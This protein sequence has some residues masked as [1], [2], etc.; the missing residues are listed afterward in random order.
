MNKYKLGI[1]AIVSITLISLA[2]LSVQADEPLEPVAFLPFVSNNSGRVRPTP[3]AFPI[4]PT[5]VAITPTPTV[6]GK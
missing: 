5:P 6:T 1:F 4:L 2:I 3:T